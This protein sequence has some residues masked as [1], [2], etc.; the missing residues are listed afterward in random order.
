MAGLSRSPFL[1][2]SPSHLLP[3]SLSL[4]L[5]NLL[6]LSLSRSLALTGT[7]LI[8]NLARVAGAR[9]HRGSTHRSFE[10]PSAF[11][12]NLRPPSDPPH[13]VLAAGARTHR[14]CTSFWIC[15]VRCWRW[16]F[17]NKIPISL[18]GTRGSTHDSHVNRH[19]NSISSTSTNSGRYRCVI[20]SREDESPCAGG[21]PSQA[22]RQHSRKPLQ[23][24]RRSTPE[25]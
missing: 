3:L 22:S 18:T 2:V 4:S 24:T 25:P 8:R 1:F 6:A 15:K 23:P 14:I 10:R 13:F 7:S 12:D 17:G 16:W 21:R 5:S 11:A 20:Q 9:K 19:F